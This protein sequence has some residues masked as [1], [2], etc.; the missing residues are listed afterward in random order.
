M[1]VGTFLT[2]SSISQSYSHCWDIRLTS[3]IERVWAVGLSKTFSIHEQLHRVHINCYCLALVH[4]AG[5]R[6]K[7]LYDWVNP[8][9]HSFCEC[10]SL[11]CVNNFLK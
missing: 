6:I 4:K 3:L 2:D 11:A 7:I 8:C 9:C 1:S 10:D 5:M